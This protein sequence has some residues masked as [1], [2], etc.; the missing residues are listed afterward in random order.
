MGEVLLTSGDSFLVQV[1]AGTHTFLADEP[2]SAGGE[3]KGP[4]PYEL[5]AAALGSCTSMTLRF[6]ANRE[7]IPLQ[8]IAIRVVHNRKHARDCANCLS[9]DGYIHHFE[10]ELDLKGDLTQQQ[11]ETLLGVAKRCPVSKTLSHE[12]RIDETLVNDGAR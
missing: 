10:L 6:Y 5:L 9:N 4:T 3:D 12:I 2:V 7:K 11:K 8:G 1:T